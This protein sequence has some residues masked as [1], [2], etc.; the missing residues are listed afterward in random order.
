VIGRDPPRHYSGAGRIAAASLARGRER[1]VAVWLDR[2]ADDQGPAVR[3]R[4]EGLEDL[5]DVEADAMAGELE[6]LAG[7]LRRGWRGGPL[8][9]H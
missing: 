5:S 1:A 3:S 9:I 2:S 4:S 8:V 6:Q 7:L